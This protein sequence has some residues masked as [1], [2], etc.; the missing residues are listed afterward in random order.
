M[1]K[2][3]EERWL[4]LPVA[5]QT[6][7]LN[8]CTQQAQHLM[9][10]VSGLERYMEA[11]RKSG[12]SCGARLR[13]VAKNMPV[14]LGQ[15]LYDKL[16]ADIAFAMMGLNAVKGVEI[17]A[18]FGWVLVDRAGWARSTRAPTVGSRS[19]EA[20]FVTCFGVRRSKVERYSHWSS[21]GSG[22]ARSRKTVVPSLRDL[23]WSGAA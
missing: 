11:L 22:V 13:V 20:S 15:P 2:A 7:R 1:L 19:A 17:G 8:S 5:Q 12:D 4:Q 21:N 23:P 9:A 10:D 18:G 14:G 16:D 3:A 6:T